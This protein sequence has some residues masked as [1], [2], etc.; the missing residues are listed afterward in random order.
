MVLRP[1]AKKVSFLMEDIHFETMGVKRTNCRRLVSSSRLFVVD[2]FD[3]GSGSVWPAD[4]RTRESA[5][6]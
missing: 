5:A 4:S 6:T 3:L 1:R 2:S